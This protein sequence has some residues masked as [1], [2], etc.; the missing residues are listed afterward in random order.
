MWEIDAEKRT[1]GQ[2]CLVDV[3]IASSHFGKFVSSW[4]IRDAMRDQIFLVETGPAVS[5]CDLLNKLKTMNV[6]R[7]D[8][9]ICTHIHLDHTGGLGH[10]IQAYPNAKIIVPEK[11]RPHLESPDRLWAGSLKVLGDIAELYTKP[12]PIPS[13]AFLDADSLPEGL[14]R[15][16]TPG[17]APHHDSYLYEL[18]DLK[19]LFN[20]DAGGVCFPIEGKEP[21]Q[22]PTTPPRFYY[23][24]ARRSLRAVEELGA[25]IICF[26]HYGAFDH[27]RELIERALM[28][29]DHW[30]DWVAEARES[31][32]PKEK[33]VDL[34]LERDPL[35][36]D[37]EKLPEGEPQRERHFMMQSISGF[38]DA[39]A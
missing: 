8:Y 11:G 22:R 37:I 15:Y 7:V 24:D 5:C 6:H 34:L 27:V 17:H 25:D 21:Y 28:Q 20:G 33:I 10:F 16:P 26:P 1:Q 36:R 30:W 31:G 2:L 4:L 38:L 29:I 13:S 39:Q 18:A 12:L 35:L 32:F 14:T 19:I 3:P 9:V 23:E